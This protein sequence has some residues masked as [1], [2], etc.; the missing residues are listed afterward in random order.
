MKGHLP[1]IGQ[2]VY[3]WAIFDSEAIKRERIRTD[4]K[5]DDPEYFFK[6]DTIEELAEDQHESVHVAQDGSEDSG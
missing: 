2:L 3:Q 4:E 5:S 6:A 1:R